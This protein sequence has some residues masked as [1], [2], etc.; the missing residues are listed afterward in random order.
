MHHLAQLTG[1]NTEVFNNVRHSLTESGRR[2]NEYQLYQS[3]M[4]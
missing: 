2:H 4:A 3:A 1:L